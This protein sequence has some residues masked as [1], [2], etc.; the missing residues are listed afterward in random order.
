[1]KIDTAYEFLKSSPLP[2]IG[3]SSTGKSFGTAV[4]KTL[5]K[6]GFD[7]VPVNPKIEKFE[8]KKCYPDISSVEG[9]PV[10]VI[11]AAKPANTMKSLDDC[12]EAGVQKIWFNQGAQSEE[13]VKFCEKNGIEAFTGNCVLMFGGGFPHNAHLFLMKLFGK[14]E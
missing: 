13:A 1:M 14:I 4:Y 11:F 7:V 6:Q 5:L 3:V 9:K 10:G 2:V 12:K 8:G